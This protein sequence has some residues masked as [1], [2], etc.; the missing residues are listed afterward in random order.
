MAE[1][2]ET[3]R[4][5]RSEKEKLLIEKRGNVEKE[6]GNGEM[7]RKREEQRGEKDKEEEKD[8]ERK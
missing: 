3:V 7:L 2:G 5:E 6:R 8:R 1:E 4:Q